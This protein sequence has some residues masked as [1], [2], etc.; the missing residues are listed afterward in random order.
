MSPET[1]VIFGVIG[2]GIFF[3]AGAYMLWWAQKGGHLENF[4]KGAKV[5]F[6]EE[7]PEGVMTDRFP[8]KRRKMKSK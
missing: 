1:Y 4:E 7:E 5:V 8:P 3:A 6:D 2:A